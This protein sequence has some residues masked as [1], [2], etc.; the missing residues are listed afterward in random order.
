MSKAGCFV[1]KSVDF[2]AG[3][4]VKNQAASAEYVVN[5]IPGSGRSP[6]G[7][8][9]NPLRYSCL[10]NLTGRGAWWAPVWGHR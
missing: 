2:L 8:N 3:S 4:V 10:G 5:L 7:G 1:R 9:G 6:G